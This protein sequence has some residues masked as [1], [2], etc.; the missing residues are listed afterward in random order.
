MNKQLNL[1]EILKGHEGDTFYCSLVGQGVTLVF[2]NDNLSISVEYINK[3]DESGNIAAHLVLYPNGANYKDGEC[4]LF[5]SKDQRDWNKWIAEQKP[6]VPKTWSELVKENKYQPYFAEIHIRFS[7]KDKCTYGKNPIEKSALA[8]LKIHQLIEVGYGGNVTNKVWKNDKFK[9]IISIDTSVNEFNIS[10]VCH[11][12][13][14][15]I[16]FYR[17]E[18]AEEFLK[19]PENVELLR[20]YFMI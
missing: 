16:A 20:D 14:T 1:C 10:S 8:L 15:P 9:F 6:K 3:E 18:Q 11:C 5:P 4:V 7:S 19:Y 2:I 12:T 13:A 17:R